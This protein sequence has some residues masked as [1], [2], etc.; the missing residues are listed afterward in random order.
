LMALMLLKDVNIKTLAGREQKGD[1]FDLKA[2]TILADS[3]IIADQP[4]QAL[5][6]TVRVEQANRKF[7]ADAV[8]IALRADNTVATVHASGNVRSNISGKAPMEMRASSADAAFGSGNSLA[9][10]VM[11][12][13]V[14]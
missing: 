2:A 8:T 12:G 6:T 3:G 14:T 7:S 4:R 5:L 13:Q 10:L 9:S 1:S 11:S